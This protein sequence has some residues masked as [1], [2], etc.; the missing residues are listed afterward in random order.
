MNFRR[1]IEP[2]EQLGEGLVQVA[3]SVQLI[4][5]ERVTLPQQNSRCQCLSI[6]AETIKIFYYF[7]C[8]TQSPDK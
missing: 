7:V 5:R 6:N 3:E 8:P 4:D 1:N 2:L